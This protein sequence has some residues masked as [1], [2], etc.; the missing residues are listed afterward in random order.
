[1]WFLF[2]FRGDGSLF[3][4]GIVLISNISV[5]G[6]YLRYLC[7]SIGS[8]LKCVLHI[9]MIQD[10]EAPLPFD[11]F[12][13]E[14]YQRLQLP[15]RHPTFQRDLCKFKVFSCPKGCPRL[16]VHCCIGVVNRLAVLIQFKDIGLT[17]TVWMVFNPDVVILVA[18]GRV[19]T[20]ISEVWVR[21]AIAVVHRCHKQLAL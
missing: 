4:L 20:I 3:K 13:E 6:D 11:A 12:V 21:D 10:G 18:L 17:A 9:L 7:Q 1:M 15:P 14:L 8:N 2:V 19:A 5:C 16:R